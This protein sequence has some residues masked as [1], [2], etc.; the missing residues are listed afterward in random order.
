MDNKI[1]S[2][3]D[4]TLLLLRCINNLYISLG[5][6]GRGDCHKDIQSRQDECVTARMKWLIIVN[7][8]RKTVSLKNHHDYLVGKQQS[9]AFFPYQSHLVLKCLVCGVNSNAL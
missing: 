9:N 4:L 5:I 8:K 7:C 6:D 3:H 1:F 2:L